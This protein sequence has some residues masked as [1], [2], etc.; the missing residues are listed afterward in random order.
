MPV[1]HYFGADAF[2]QREAYDKLRADHDGDGA[3]AANTL[4]LDGPRTTPGEVAAAAMTAPFLADHRLVR[5]D[6]LCRPYNRQGNQP[7]GKRRRRRGLGDWDGLPDRLQNLPPSTLLVFLDGDIRPGNLMKGLLAQ[8]A[9]E[10]KEFKPAKGRQLDAWVRARVQRAGVHLTGRAER[11]LVARVGAD[12]GALASEI[13]KLRLYAGDDTV[14]EHVIERICP[15]NLEAEIW[16]LTDAVGQGR[17]EAALRA[18]E[19]LRQSGEDNGG[20]L[21]TLASQMRRIPV[22]QEILAQGGDADAVRQH[23]HMRHPYP[24]QKLAEQARRFT[25]AQAA[26]ALPRIRDCDAAIQRYRRD[27]P[28]GLHDDVALELLVVD[29]A[30]G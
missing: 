16:D 6:G 1:L 27:L 11:A 4:V 21:R 19:T 30:A 7:A 9:H 2:S 15:R 14:D 13:E 8:V 18:L 12:Q 29:L 22:A 24:A 20:L 28:G 25:P 17:P 3:L 10:S 26:A 5:V 23:F